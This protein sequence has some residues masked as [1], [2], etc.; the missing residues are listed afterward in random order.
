[1]GKSATTV[2]GPSGEGGGA[3]EGGLHGPPTLRS[4]ECEDGGLEN[5]K[6]QQSSGGTPPLETWT[7]WTVRKQDYTR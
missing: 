4:G 1:M 2:Q 3:S 7:P 6:R 5:A